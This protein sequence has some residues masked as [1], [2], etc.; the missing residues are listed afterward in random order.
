MECLKT[1]VSGWHS[2]GI[3]KIPT[4]KTLWA[5]LDKSCL[6]T[7]LLVHNICEKR[8]KEKKEKRENQAIKS[9]SVSVF[10]E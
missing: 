4:V 1:I 2:L 9:S 6:K 10:V 7:S 3:R 8:K 5:Q